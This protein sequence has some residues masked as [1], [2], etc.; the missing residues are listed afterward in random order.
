[1]ITLETTYKFDKSSHRFMSVDMAIEVAERIVTSASVISVE[2]KDN[3]EVVFA[4]NHN[5]KDEKKD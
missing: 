2:V 4:K 5:F 3:D 1:M